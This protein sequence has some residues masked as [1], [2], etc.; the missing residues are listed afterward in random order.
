MLRT[1]LVPNFSRNALTMP[2]LRTIVENGT[3]IQDPRPKHI[4][5]Q[6]WR[7]K[8]FTYV[9]VLCRLVT[10]THKAKVCFRKNSQVGGNY[11]PF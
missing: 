8:D 4:P 2:V 7:S 10:G 11:P 5:Y 9:Y 3:K 6:R 1:F